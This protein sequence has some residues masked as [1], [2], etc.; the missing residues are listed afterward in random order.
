MEILPLEIQSNVVE[1]MKYH[2]DVLAFRRTST[3]SR[4]I[5]DQMLRN[6]HEQ[7]LCWLF[8]HLM[9][10]S[11]K[12]QPVSAGSKT[13]YLYI[14]PLPKYTTFRCACCGREADGILTCNCVKKPMKKIFTGPCIAITFVMLLSACRHRI[15]TFNG[16]A[17]F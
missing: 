6:E 16:I 9:I 3:T 8:N 12:H 2:P 7:E 15:S 1:H 5:V 13:Y 11:A 17:H 10:S 14:F 4:D